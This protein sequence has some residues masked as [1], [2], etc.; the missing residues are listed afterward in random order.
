MAMWNRKLDLY[1][2]ISRFLLVIEILLTIF[3]ALIEETNKTTKAP[4]LNIVIK[5]KSTLTY[6]CW[7][8]RSTTLST[9]STSSSSWWWPVPLETETPRKMARYGSQRPLNLHWTLL[10]I[11]VVFVFDFNLAPQLS[12]KWIETLYYHGNTFLLRRE[13]EFTCRSCFFFHFRHLQ[14]VYMRWKLLT[15]LKSKQCLATSSN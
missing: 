6:R 13:Y 5:Y 15:T 11:R 4:Y 7:T 10:N 12:Q 3:D 8:W 14:R 2:K 1:H 9:W